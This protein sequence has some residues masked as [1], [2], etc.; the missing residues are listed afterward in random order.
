[1]VDTATGSGPFAGCRFGPSIANTKKD[2]TAK[3]APTWPSL[4]REGIQG[5]G[6]AAA[7]PMT[8][9]CLVLR[10]EASSVAPGPTAGCAKVGRSLPGA[11]ADQLR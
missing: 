3:D 2:V 1:M 10:I 11:G 7:D 6:G 9:L 4:A 8:Q 5:L